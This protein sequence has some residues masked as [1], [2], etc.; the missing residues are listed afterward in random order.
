MARLIIRKRQKQAQYYTEDLG[1]GI[2][3]DMMLIPAGTFFMGSPDNEL[4]RSPNEGPQHEVN[5]PSF[6]LGKYPVTQG[7]WRAVSV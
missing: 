6:F 4:E 2:T 5:I 3:M 1:N 7:Q